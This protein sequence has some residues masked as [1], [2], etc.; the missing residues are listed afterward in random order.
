M[1]EALRIENYIKL[2]NP[3]LLKRKN[4]KG[5]VSGIGQVF[6]DMMVFAYE[7]GEQYNM[8]KA[9]GVFLDLLGKW[10]GVSRNLELRST[11][12]RM[13]DETYRKVIKAKIAISTWDGTMGSLPGILNSVFPDISITVTD[14]Q[15]MTVTATVKSQLS[16]ILLDILN[17]GLL[18]PRTYGVNMKYVLPTQTTDEEIPIKRGHALVSFMQTGGNKQ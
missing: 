10:T 4:I 1:R 6:I 14:H 15:N 11:S 13:D 9:Q 17:N 5:L 18:I 8:E 16:D 12:S 3:Q 7:L 2:M